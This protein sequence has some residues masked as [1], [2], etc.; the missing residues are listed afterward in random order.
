[1]EKTKIK[2]ISLILALSIGGGATMLYFYLTSEACEAKL[3]EKFLAFFV[4]FATSF[5]INT[6]IHFRKLRKGE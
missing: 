5:I 6:I 3:F 1:M 2:I 4:G